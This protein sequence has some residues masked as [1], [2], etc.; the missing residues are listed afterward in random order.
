[1]ATTAWAWYFH[2][3]R[4][5]DVRPREIKLAGGLLSLWREEKFFIMV[6]YVFKIKSPLGTQKVRLSESRLS[7]CRIREFK[8]SQGGLQNFKFV[9]F[10]KVI[11]YVYRYRAI[12]IHSIDWFSISISIAPSSHSCRNTSRPFTLFQS[13]LYNCSRNINLNIKI[14]SKAK[15]SKAK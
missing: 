8:A 14:S 4:T 5:C 1:M 3:A 10:S 6:P 12:D 9:S 15:Q 11:I 2:L 13:W 7:R